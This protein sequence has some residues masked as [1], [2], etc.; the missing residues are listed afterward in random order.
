MND[1]NPVKLTFADIVKLCTLPKYCPPN[2]TIFG[3]V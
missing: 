1:G 2:T 3:N